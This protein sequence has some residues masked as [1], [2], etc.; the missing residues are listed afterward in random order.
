LP[1]SWSVNALNK[2][3]SLA[4]GDAR[5]AIQT[6]KNAAYNAEN[7]FSRTVKKNHI[8]KG[9]SSVKIRNRTYLL[10]KLSSHH[11]LLYELVKKK[12]SIH[13]GQLWKV[14][15]EKCGELKKQPIALR[16]FSE[17]MNK[18]IELDLVQWDRALV[19]G[20]V[21]VFKTSE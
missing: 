9:Y 10:D 19:R 4:E 13:S 14:Y 12:K 8:K 3:A 21:R 16:T 17:Y 15:L 1:G 6:L 20:K 11:R 5:V 7:D 18:L 2:I